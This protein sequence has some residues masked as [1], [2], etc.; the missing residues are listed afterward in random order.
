MQQPELDCALELNS[1]VLGISGQSR[2]E[3]REALCLFLRQAVRHTEAQSVPTVQGLTLIASQGLAAPTPHSH[4]GDLQ[5]LRSSLAGALSVGK[6]GMKH[7][8]CRRQILNV[9]FPV[10][11]PTRR[12]AR[13]LCHNR[14]LHRRFHT[15]RPGEQALHSSCS[16]SS[17]HQLP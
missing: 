9:N 12:R 7:A 1:S 14:L 13:D 5:S 6:T 8:A 2:H 3:L 15:R 16:L 17:L 11:A 10:S 4:L